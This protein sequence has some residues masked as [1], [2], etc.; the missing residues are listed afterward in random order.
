[1]S[2]IFLFLFLVSFCRS[3]PLEF[4]GPF[5]WICISAIPTIVFAPKIWSNQCHLHWKS[6]ASWQHSQNQIWP[7]LQQELRGKNPEKI[8]GC[9]SFDNQREQFAL[10][11]MGHTLIDPDP[12]T[13]LSAWCR[14]QLI[15]LWLGFEQ[16]IF[17]S[18][19]SYLVSPIPSRCSRQLMAR[20]RRSGYSQKMMT[21][22]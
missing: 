9:I 3:I 6:F 18:S 17:Y 7:L 13:I 14:Q 4:L 10:R 8:L 15:E 5:C 22:F 21:S 11:C 20:V 1:M 19:Y 2:S 12:F 16:S